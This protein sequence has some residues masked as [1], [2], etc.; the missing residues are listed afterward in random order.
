[1]YSRLVTTCYCCKRLPC[2]LI[3]TGR[4]KT[5]AIN[6]RLV[7][8]STAHTRWGKILL[9]ENKG[10]TYYYYW[11]LLCIFTTSGIP[12]TEATN[13]RLVGKSSAHTRSSNGSHILTATLYTYHRG[14]FLE[15]T[16]CPTVFNGDIGCH[17]RAGQHAHA[18]LLLSDTHCRGHE[19]QAGRLLWAA[20]GRGEG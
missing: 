9:M 16:L 14:A 1:M 6:W 12:K 2:I 18:T 7:S 13:W 20:A 11:R 19:E 3:T 4:P 8:K 10:T 15:S 17:V 5:E